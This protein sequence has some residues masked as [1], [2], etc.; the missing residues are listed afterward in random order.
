MYQLYHANQKAHIT[1]TLSFGNSEVVIKV[2]KSL[3]AGDPTR[4]QTSVS[5]N[6][7]VI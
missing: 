6:S 4:L 5:M 7:F 2:A 1:P 3:L